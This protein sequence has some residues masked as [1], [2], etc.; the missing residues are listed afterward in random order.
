MS[1]CPGCSLMR[2]VKSRACTSDGP[3]GVDAT[4]T[5]M[6]RCCAGVAALSTASPT[7]ATSSFMSKVRFE[8]DPAA[9][10]QIVEIDVRALRLLVH[11][12]LEL[13]VGLRGAAHRQQRQA[14]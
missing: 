2:G 7:R 11:R 10:H 13:T 4:S 8:A 3:A 6:G 5:R 14:F 12:E 9:L 1:V